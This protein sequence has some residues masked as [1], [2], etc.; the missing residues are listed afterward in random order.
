MAEVL[1]RDLVS[2]LDPD[3]V[4]NIASGGCWARPNNPATPTA[5]LVMQDRGIDLS[6]HLSQPV[7]EA[8]LDSINLIL[9]MEE[10]HKRHIQ[11]NF[12]SAKDKTFLLYEMIGKEKEIWDPI[13]MS[14]NAY[15]NTAN[16][17]LEIMTE[18]FELISKKARE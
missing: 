8:L 11:R 16:E 17:I 14:Q 6:E 5:V 12:P 1:F 18:G 13:G 7:T 9:C 15:E 2:K 4:W 3:T 10:E